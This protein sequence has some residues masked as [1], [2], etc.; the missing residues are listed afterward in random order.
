MVPTGH[1]LVVGRHYVE[2]FKVTVGD[3]T[4]YQGTF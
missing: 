1:H 4:Y 2:V 3:Q